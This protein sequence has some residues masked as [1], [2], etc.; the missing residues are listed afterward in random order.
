M[1]KLLVLTPCIAILAA[2]GG[3][4]GAGGGSVALQP[5]MWETTV[6]FSN[7]EVPGVPE[8][9]VAAMRQAMSRPQTRSECMTPE[10]AANPSGNMMNPGGQAGACQ[11]SKSTFANGTIDVAGSCNAGG[12][13]S[14]NM[15]MAGTYTPTTM[16]ANVTTAVRPPAGTPGPQEVRMTGSLSARRTGDCPGGAAAGNSQ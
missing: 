8:A 10:Q 11:F 14:L 12:R 15:T 6:T 4:G 9:Q 5:G 2:C 16:T 3:S 13:G 1:K 7:I